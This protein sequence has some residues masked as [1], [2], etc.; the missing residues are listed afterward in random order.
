M[1]ILARLY[2]RIRAREFAYARGRNGSF[3]PHH[4]EAQIIH[5]DG[6]SPPYLRLSVFSQRRTLDDAPLVL[7]LELAEWEREALEIAR[8]ARASRREPPDRS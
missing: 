6:T 2:F 7:Q 5:P 8:V 4:V 3:V 1:Q